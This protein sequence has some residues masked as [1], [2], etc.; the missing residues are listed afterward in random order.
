MPPPKRRRL[1]SLNGLRAFEVAGRRQ[2]F[3]LAAEEIG[4]TQGAIAQHIRALE[5]DL[6]LKLFERTP[7]SVV[8]TEVGRTYLSHVS[9]AF[10][11]LSEATDELREDPNQVT[12]NVT[13]SF[14]SRW[15]LPHLQEFR[16]A[17]PE[18]EVSILATESM[19]DFR[20]SDAN[21][22][23]RDG[24]P[25][26]SASV[27]HDLLFERRLVA[28]ASPKLIEEKGLPT[29]SE[30]LQEFVLLHDMENE[31]PLFMKSVFGTENFTST[32]NIN[33]N[34]ATLA[35]DGAIASQGIA[36]ASSLF[37]QAEVD[38]GRLVKLFGAE[39]RADSDYYIIKS[40]RSRNQVATEHVWDWLVSCKGQAAG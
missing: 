8:L 38:G 32:N 21:L 27:Q 35:I 2:N 18:V 36:L 24:H 7:R 22:A 1:P 25:P 33:F 20:A 13:P 34:F 11:L 4:V 37:V 28:V 39:V 15:L 29:T 16:R 9:R 14:A 5:D 3:R 12:I 19:P 6:G 17:Y 23:I 31:W 40:A 26:F 10:E 30:D